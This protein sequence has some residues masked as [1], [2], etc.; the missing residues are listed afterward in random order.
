MVLQREVYFKELVQA[1]VVL[2]SLNSTGQAFQ[3]LWP[4]GL[5]QSGAGLRPPWESSIFALEAF[6]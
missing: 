6:D 2:A 5:L 3:A 1:T 4:E